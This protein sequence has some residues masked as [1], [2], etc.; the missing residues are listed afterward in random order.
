VD[1]DLFTYKILERCS[2]LARQPYMGRARPELAY[3]LR[4]I[5]LA[6]YMIFYRPS[7]NG[8]E[9]VRILHGSRDI[10][11]LFQGEQEP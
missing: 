10:E 8:V 3:N 6:R 9:I 7:S 1:A 2:L 5:A 4:S 11:G